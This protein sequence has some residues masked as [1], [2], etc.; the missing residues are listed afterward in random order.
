MLLKAGTPRSLSAVYRHPKSNLATFHYTRCD[1]KTSVVQCFQ[2]MLGIRN[3]LGLKPR[4]TPAPTSPL[5]RKGPDDTEIRDASDL[6]AKAA[7]HPDG[8][9]WRNDSG[10]RIY[11]LEFNLAIK[12]WLTPSP[13]RRSFPLFPLL[14]FKSRDISQ[15]SLRN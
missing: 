4:P 10:T 5:H 3:S 13:S 14:C 7:N 6:A 9:L 8:N 11:S 1:L 12:P 2:Q 15:T